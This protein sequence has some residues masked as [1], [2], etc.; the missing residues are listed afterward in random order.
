MRRFE[1]DV[2]SIFTSEVTPVWAKEWF[3][4]KVAFYKLAWALKRPTWGLAVLTLAAS[5]GAVGATVLAQAQ[6]DLQQTKDAVTASMLVLVFAYACAWWMDGARAAKSS[7]M[8][9]VLV[10]MGLTIFGGLLAK[11]GS[12]P[13]AAL[14]IAVAFSYMM[15]ALNITAAYL[16]VSSVRVRWELRRQA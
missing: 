5:L 10:F 1:Y 6:P 9:G 15:M 7:A 2:K 4:Q 12:G 3:K 14:L 8:S 16:V 11:D 13:A